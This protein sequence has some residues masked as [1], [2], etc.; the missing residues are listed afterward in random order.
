MDEIK[1]DAVRRDR[2][3]DARGTKSKKSEWQ[4]PKLEFV[5]PRLTERGPLKEM[6]GGFFGTFSP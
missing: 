5:E 2:G 1:A 3:D 6:A 4:D